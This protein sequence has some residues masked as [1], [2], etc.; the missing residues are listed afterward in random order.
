MSAQFASWLKMI[1]MNVQSVIKAAAE[2]ASLISPQ[3][4]AKEIQASANSNALFAILSQYST[5]QTKYGAIYSS[6]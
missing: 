3:N 6:I 4:R 2:N 1:S 5:S